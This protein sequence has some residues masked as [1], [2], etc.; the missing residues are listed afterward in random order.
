MRGQPGSEL[1][2]LACRPGLGRL[3]VPLGWMAAAGLP[4][5]DPGV[6][7]RQVGDSTQQHPGDNLDH[8]SVPA[9]SHLEHRVGVG[10]VISDCVLNQHPSGGLFLPRT[11]LKKVTIQPPSIFKFSLGSLCTP[12]MGVNYPA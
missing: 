2:A 8:P 4:R 6:G 9:G 1:A 10:L 7:A 12:R 5:K 3:L 11:S